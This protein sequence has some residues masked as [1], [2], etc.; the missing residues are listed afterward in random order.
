VVWCITRTFEDCATVLQPFSDAQVNQ[1]LYYLISPGAGEFVFELFEASVPWEQRKR[2][3]QAVY[4]LFEQCFAVRCSPHLSH[5]DEAGV[6]P[7]NAVCYM[8]W[9]TWPRPDHPE[10]AESDGTLLD[11]MARTLML[12]SDA[13]RESALHGLNHWAHDY[14]E[15][16]RAIIDRHLSE[17]PP[18]RE[19][20]RWYAERASRGGLL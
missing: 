15:Q 7:L 5:R 4:T 10:A 12:D 8:W 18:V 3:L 14:P 17:C 6:N 11:V 16:M 19:E 20:L 9:D 2:A 13:C 1:G